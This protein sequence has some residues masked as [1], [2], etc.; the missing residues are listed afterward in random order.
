MG[1]VQKADKEKAYK[2]LIY[3]PLLLLCGGAGGNRTFVK[4]KYIS[5]LTY[6]C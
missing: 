4:H 5:T 6:Y 2:S 3:K 1:Y